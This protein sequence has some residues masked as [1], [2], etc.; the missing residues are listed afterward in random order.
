MSLFLLP[1]MASNSESHL[2]SKSKSDVHSSFVEND[3]GENFRAF[4]ESVGERYPEEELVYQTLRGRLRRRFVLSYLVRLRGRLLDLGCNRGV[5]VQAYQ[6][7]PVVGVDLAYSVLRVAARRC[8]H[9]G[10]VQGD[11]QNLAFFRDCVFDAVLCSEVL[12]HVPHPERLLRETWR[13]LVPGGRLF[14]TTPN[15][16]KA[17][18]RW[19]ALGVMKAY[20]VEGIREGR[21]YHTAFRPEELQLMA[22]EVGFEV[23]EAGTFEKEVK[24]SSR[25]PVLFFHLLRLLNKTL[26]R[27]EA[28]QAFNERQL[29]LWTSRT[30]AFLRRMGLDRL[31]E[32]WVREG[33]RSYLLAVRR[34]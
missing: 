8:P 6:N 19:V 13:V 14:L 29:E 21:Y 24:Y 22:E 3:S 2:L 5:Y 25:I 11:A 15:Y 4:Y 7:G 16:K 18:P 1:T 32:R 27:S 31:C 10:F 30:Y 23:L 12:E 33:V 34:S 26:L 9:A 17:R 20:G 28:V